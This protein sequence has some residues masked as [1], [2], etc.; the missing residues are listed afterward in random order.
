MR[1]L[2]QKTFQVIL[3]L[4]LDLLKLDFLMML[5]IYG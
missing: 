5:K 2:A 4:L 3:T 1:Q